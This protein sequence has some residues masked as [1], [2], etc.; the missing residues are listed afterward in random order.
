MVVLSSL[1]QKLQ[2]QIPTTIKSSAN[3]YPIF[4]VFL[5]LPEVKSEKS[6]PMSY[7][8]YISYEIDDGFKILARIPV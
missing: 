2:L 8:D 1:S 4:R 7:N 6:L 3:F 5:F